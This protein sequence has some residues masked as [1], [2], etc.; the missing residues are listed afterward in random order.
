MGRSSSITRMRLPRATDGLLLWLFCIC[1]PRILRLQGA[2]GFAATAGSILVFACR[3]WQYNCANELLC[4]RVVFC[5]VAAA[6]R[7]DNCPYPVQPEAV[8]PLAGGLERRTT[9][10]LRVSCEIRCFG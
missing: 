3:E 7:F 6:M 5:L 10:F 8:A 2:W 4:R 1:D 9:P